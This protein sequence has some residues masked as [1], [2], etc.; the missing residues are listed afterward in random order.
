MIDH[1][2]INCTDLP[3]AAAFYDRVLGVLAVFDKESRDGVEA[4]TDDDVPLVVSLANQAA[5]SIENARLYE[6]ATVDGLTKLYIRRHFEQRLSEE[7]RRAE[8]YGTVLSLMI[9]DIDHFKKFNDTYGHQTGDEVIKLVARTLK[10]CIR[11][12]IDVP[13]RFGGEE[14]VV[15]LPETDAIRQSLPAVD[16]TYG[17]RQAGKVLQRCGQTRNPFFAQAQPVKQ[18]S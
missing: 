1:L 15:F 18:G 17:I 11:I 7:L 10:D 3:R 12:G 8:R 4:F 13:G 2:G 16:G 14:L 9:L 5:T 6:L